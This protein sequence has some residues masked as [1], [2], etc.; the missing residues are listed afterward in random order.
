M[1][2]FVSEIIMVRW[3]AVKLCRWKSGTPQEIRPDLGGGF[4]HVLFSARSLGKWSNLTV[5]YFSNGLVQPPTSDTTILSKLWVI[6]CK[7]SMHETT[8]YWLSKTREKTKTKKAD[9]DFSSPNC[10]STSNVS[11]NHG[12]WFESWFFQSDV[13]LQKCWKNRTLV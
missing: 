6:F 2:K 13:K 11:S 9:Q 8:V 10:P 3:K 7:Y 4:K 5:A 12:P 1:R